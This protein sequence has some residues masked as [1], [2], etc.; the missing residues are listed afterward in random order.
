MARYWG[1]K[2]ERVRSEIRPELQDVVDFIIN[3]VCDISLI[4]GYRDEKEQN[5]LYPTFS[6]VRWPNSKHNTSPSL[7]VDLQPY[8]YP[9]RTSELREQLSYIAGRAT[10]WAQ[11]R[12]I[13]LRW[14]G[15][16]NRNGSILDNHFDDLFHFE[17]IPHEMYN[18]SN[19]TP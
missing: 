9:K 16:W 7:A 6:K 17:I 12:N 18:R 10:Q 5:S 11:S 15:D 14:G 13:A 19:T 4:T 1:P 3:E 2:S 8:P